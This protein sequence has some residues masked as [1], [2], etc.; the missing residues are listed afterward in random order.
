MNE[1]GPLL[2]LLWRQV[3]RGDLIKLQRQDR[4]DKRLIARIAAMDTDIQR[5]MHPIYFNGRKVD[6]HTDDRGPDWEGLL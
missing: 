2:E 3:S 4:C 6:A 5:S 1:T